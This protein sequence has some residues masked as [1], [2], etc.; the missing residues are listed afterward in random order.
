MDL[1]VS[2]FPFT[3]TKSWCV[4]SKITLLCTMEETKCLVY[5]QYNGSEN[6]NCVLWFAWSAYSEL[7]EVVSCMKLSHIFIFISF[8]GKFLLLFVLSLYYSS[9]YSSSLN[10]SVSLLT[11]ASLLYVILAEVVV[12]LVNKEDVSNIRICNTYVVLKIIPKLKVLLP[13]IN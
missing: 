2:R 6:F 3:L 10:W 7:S 4:Y 9:S 11:L 13:T 1:R 8:L 5:G 12:V